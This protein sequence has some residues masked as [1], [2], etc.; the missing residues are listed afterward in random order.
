MTDEKF[1]AIATRNLEPAPRAQVMSY[2]LIIPAL[3][4]AESIGRVLAQLP[5]ARLQEIIV[6]DNG[7]QD[8]TAAVARDAGARV[9][10]ETRRGY[11]R[12]CQ[13]GISALDA[14]VN[15]VVFM[16]ADLSDDPADIDRLLCVFEAGNFDLVL[17]SRSL[18]CAERGSLTAVQRFGNWL[19]TKLIA[20]LWGVRFTDL[21][22]LRVIR[23]DALE[24]I[25][26]QDEGFGWNVEMQSKAA[27]LRLKTGEIPVNYRR[28][29]FGR[30]K[31]SGTL[32]GSA[33]AGF[34]ILATVG[35]CWL[36]G[37]LRN[38]NRMLKGSS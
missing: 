5:R 2:A 20:C 21:G 33:Q 34:K 28:R 13:T 31:I 7:S 30:S 8:N 25:A 19:T 26:L 24:R 10:L 9:V 27:M 32:A 29:K 11:G 37:W 15:A 35:R 16:D 3:N 36:S 1:R 18:G 23:R 17:G 38:P 6:V 22:P 14:G 4:E 12:A